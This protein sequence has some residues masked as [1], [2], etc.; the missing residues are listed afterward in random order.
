MLR[1]L[2][3]SRCRMSLLSWMEAKLLLD[4]TK[5]SRFGNREPNLRTSAQSWRLL[6][7]MWSR[8]SVGQATLEA[9]TQLYSLRHRNSSSSLQRNRRK[10]GATRPAPSHSDTTT[11]LSYSGI[12]RVSSSTV[13]QDTRVLLRTRRRTLAKASAHRG[14]RGIP[15]RG[16]ELRFRNSR[17]GMLDTILLI[18]N[19]TSCH[20]LAIDVYSIFTL[21]VCFV[22]MLHAQFQAFAF[23][24]TK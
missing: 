22:K 13:S 24:M 14:S 21:V 5:V 7:V 4:M 20:Y 16:L 17:L 9:L 6:S 1:R 11:A 10:R 19:K 2:G 23:K 3:K 12:S 15:A 18:W 8:R